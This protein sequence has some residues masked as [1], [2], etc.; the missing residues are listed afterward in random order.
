ML[1]P[2]LPDDFAYLNAVGSDQSAMWVVTVSVSGRPSQFKVDTR[3]EVTVISSAASTQL[4]ITDP[5]PTTK[6][7]RGPDGTPLC[8]VGQECMHTL[9]ILPSLLHNLLGLPA[10]R[11][12]HVL[13]KVDSLGEP[14]QAKFP[15]LFTGLEDLK[16]DPYEIQLESDATSFSLNTA[17]NVPLP[18]CEKIQAE[19][20]RVQALDAIAPVEEPTPWC[21]GMVVVPKKSGQ[22]R[23]C[24][25]YRV[26]A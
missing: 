6:Q 2:E 23:I 26:F 7:L 1:D 24:V 3:A 25:D 15:S 22:V 14:P 5:Q 16:E 10:I 17:H 20:Q 9:F 12:L 18:L 8:T 21:S 19:L 4:G 13:Q 11:N